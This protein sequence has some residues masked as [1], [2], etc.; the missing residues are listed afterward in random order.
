MRFQI[1]GRYR[2]IRKVVLLPGD[3]GKIIIPFLDATICF[4]QKIDVIFISYLNQVAFP[5]FNPTSL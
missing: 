5:I 2:F 1:S 4:R 3:V